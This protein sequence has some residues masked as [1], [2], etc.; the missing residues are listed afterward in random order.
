M[1]QL[2]SELLNLTLLEGLCA[3]ITI[4]RIGSRQPCTS[5]GISIYVF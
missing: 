1:F 4:D 5:Y 3:C 2:R